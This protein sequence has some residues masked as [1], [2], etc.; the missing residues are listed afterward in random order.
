MSLIHESF[1]WSKSALTKAVQACYYVDLAPIFRIHLN[2][3]IVL[4]V[5][6]VTV[7]MWYSPSGIWSQHTF[8]VFCVI[9]YLEGFICSFISHSV[10][11]CWNHTEDSGPEVTLPCHSQ[12]SKVSGR[13]GC[14]CF[15]YLRK[16]LSL[17]LRLNDRM[18][19]VLT[20][21]KIKEKYEWIWI[22]E[23]RRLFVQGK[24]TK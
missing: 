19:F 20:D 21:W 9:D 15:L 4:P 3:P 18:C 2:S 10:R 24:V 13:T 5:L 23:V 11:W 14:L 8:Q 22:W 16:G 17:M 1:T 6:L 12:H 7:I